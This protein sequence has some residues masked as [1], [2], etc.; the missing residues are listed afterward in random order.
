[1]EVAHYDYEEALNDVK[2]ACCI[3]DA[4]SMAAFE[5]QHVY[6]SEGLRLVATVLFEAIKRVEAGKDVIL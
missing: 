1:M 6:E 2:G 4:M 3:V 5:S